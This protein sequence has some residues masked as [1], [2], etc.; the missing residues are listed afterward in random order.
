[1]PP[2]PSG[3][4][5]LTPPVLA[6]KRR[7]RGVSARARRASSP[8]LMRLYKLYSVAFLTTLYEMFIRSALP[9]RDLAAPRSFLVLPA[10]LT[11]VKVH[12][13]TKQL[14]S[15]ES[16]RTQ[17][18]GKI[19]SEQHAGGW[20]C[21]GEDGDIGGA[22]ERGGRGNSR[23]LARAR[24]PTR[25]ASGSFTARRRN[26]QRP[27]LRILLHRRRQLA[28]GAHRDHT[29]RAGIRRGLRRRRRGRALPAERRRPL[30]DGLRRELRN[31]AP[32]RRHRRAAHKL[33]ARCADSTTPSSSTRSR[34]SKSTTLAS[35]R[36]RCWTRSFRT[37]GSSSVLRRSTSQR[38]LGRSH[39][40]DRPRSSCRPSS[41][42][43]RGRPDLQHQGSEAE[44]QE[45]GAQAEADGRRP[46]GEAGASLAS[47][48]S[49]A[50]WPACRSYPVGEREADASRSIVEYRSH[51]GAPHQERRRA[52]RPSI[53]P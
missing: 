50:A 4:L 18:M 24:R 48:P 30:A 21:D 27:K 45:A 9:A 1:M 14:V 46:Q 52:R 13:P 47:L 6:R 2:C 31:D 11:M 34:S 32:A 38:A 17:S 28:K 7:S 37:L 49:D 40:Q 44:E 22:Q 15:D 51:L 39:S 10:T 16:W 26:K 35:T 33:A 29:A 25:C 12:P 41:L 23:Q 3:C 43:P 36:G 5:R 53:R 19:V 20:R 42:L 8:L